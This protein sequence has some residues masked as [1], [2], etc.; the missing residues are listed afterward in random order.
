MLNKI[1]R[2]YNG[3][4][5]A[6]NMPSHREGNVVFIGGPISAGIKYHW[7][8]KIARVVVNF[9]FK[10]WQWLWGI[11]VAVILGIWALP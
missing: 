10:N 9:Y 8:A 11:F 5:A 1:K 6:I 3:N 7:T 2:W 4:P